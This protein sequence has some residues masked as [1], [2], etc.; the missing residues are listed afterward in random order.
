VDGPDRTPVSVGD[1]RGATVKD[2]RMSSPT[3]SRDARKE[4]HA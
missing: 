1:P 2:A 3:P 4:H